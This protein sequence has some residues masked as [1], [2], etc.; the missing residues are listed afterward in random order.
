VNGGGGVAITPDGPRGP[1]EQMAEGTPLLAKAS[2]VPVLFVGLATRPC[3][4][5]GSWDAAMVPLP[6]T[7]GAIV[8][9]RVDGVPRDTDEAGLKAANA[10]WAARLSAVTRRAELMLA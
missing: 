5:L 1:T 8:W 10:D 9:D 4:R 2:G 7:R 3:L 6:F